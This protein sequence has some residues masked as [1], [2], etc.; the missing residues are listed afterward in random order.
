MA[1]KDKHVWLRSLRGRLDLTHAD[2]R[3]LVLLSTFADARGRNAFPGARKLADAMGVKDA[4]AVRSRLADLVARGYLAVASGGTVKGGQRQASCYE[5]LP[6]PA[7][8][9]DEHPGSGDPTTGARHPGPEAPTTG[10]EPPGS[11]GSATGDPDPRSPAPGDP[12]SSAPVVPPVLSTPPSDQGSDQV[13]D[14]QGSPSSA[15][16]L[17]ARETNS[18]RPNAQNEARIR[19]NGHDR[20]HVLRWHGSYV[21]DHGSN[22]LDRSLGALL[23]AI[24]EGGA[25]RAEAVFACPYLEAQP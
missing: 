21:L 3:A 24:E 5:L 23:K 2:F 17:M 9:G 4:D 11:G 25:D 20:E 16:R 7:T 13:P 12:P 14:Q 1:V 22:D 10:D 19:D 18:W 6:V 8:T 15:P